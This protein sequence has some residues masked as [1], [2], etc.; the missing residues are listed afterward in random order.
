MFNH[1][2][3]NQGIHKKNSFFIITFL[4]KID[5]IIVQ[6]S[7]KGFKTAVNFINY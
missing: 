4:W 2:E 3:V 7:K 1:I 5:F 6:I